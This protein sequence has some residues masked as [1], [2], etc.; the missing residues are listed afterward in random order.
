MVKE[1]AF[2]SLAQGLNE[3][4]DKGLIVSDKRFNAKSLRKECASYA[5]EYKDKIIQ[6]AKEGGYFVALQGPYGPIQDPETK[7][8]KI[9]NEDTFK[10]YLKE[11]KKISEE[12]NNPIWG[13]TEIEGKMICEKYKVQI[14]AIELRNEEV[15]G[16]HVT[17]SEVGK[18]S[19]TIYIVNY[20]NHFVPLL[21]DLQQD[22]KEISREEAYEVPHSL[23]ADTRELNKDDVDKWA[24]PKISVRAEDSTATRFDG[25]IIL[26]LEDDPVVMEAA[27]RLAAK[28]P[29][30]SVIVQLDAQ[31]NYQEVYGNLDTL[32]G[33]ENLRWQVVGHGRSNI[34]DKTLG[35]YSATELADEIA[36]FTIELD[37]EYNISSSPKYISLVG[38]SLVDTI[39]MNY[40]RELA[41]SLDEQGIRADIAARSARV[42]VT[43]TGKKL[44]EDSSGKWK[45][46][47]SEDKIIY[48]WNQDG[49]LVP[50]IGKRATELLKSIDLAENF[51]QSMSELYKSNQLPEG[52]WWPILRNV[53]KDTKTDSYQVK[54]INAEQQLQTAT[55]HDQRIINFIEDYNEK[56]AIVKEAYDN[57]GTQGR[58]V[59]DVESVDG[60]NS[61]FI[62]K[63]L[64][65]WFANKSRMA[66]ADDN[67]PEILKTALQVHTW[68]NLAQM[69]HG[70]VEDID[71]T[72]GLYEAAI[73]ISEGKEVASVTTSS[74]Q[75][76]ST[77]AGVL[78]NIGSVVLDSITAIKLRE[79]EVK[80][81]QKI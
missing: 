63:T 47:I 3:L 59:F 46:K 26:Q 57:A 23:D 39:E 54:F 52:K 24:K 1:I 13:R 73:A 66:V 77:G 79:R 2:D 16:L 31:R 61:A 27:A 67:V 21:S 34:I 51:H 22:I 68:V 78:L 64:I 37:T 80:I 44:T 50:Q 75:H 30:S 71:K 20:K 4:K 70:A 25:Q 6:D 55:T 10:L 56:L 36:D 5:D 69:G 65:P 12:S 41:L 9:D 11:I 42:A 49:E 60:L 35:G 29:E 40:A 17:T 15:G 81:G 33:Q 62:V 76:V 58:S 18:N 53:A 48:A 14:T 19:N 32:K 43:Y 8:N 74:L 72:A 28:H 7:E 45:H 38:C